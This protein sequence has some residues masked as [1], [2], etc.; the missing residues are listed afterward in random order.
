[1]LLRAFGARIGRDVHIYPNVRIIM[2][3]NVSIGDECAIG[4]RVVIYSLGRITIGKKVTVSQQAHLCAGTHDHR[5]PDFPLVKTP[6]V[7]GD[8]VWICAD[9]FI[10]PGVRVG[11]GAVIGARAVAIKDVPRNAIVVGNPART[12]RERPEHCDQ[13]PKFR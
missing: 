7:I 11:Y 8:G 12:V 4:E 3:W 10:G 13:A 2:P 6:I 5:R 1:M 9:A